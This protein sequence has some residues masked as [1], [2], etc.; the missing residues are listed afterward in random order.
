MANAVTV[1]IQPTRGNT[2][3]ANVY[4]YTGYGVRLKCSEIRLEI[5]AKCNRED[6]IEDAGK[7]D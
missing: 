5:D 2:A 3:R 7:F 4:P 6:A 1:H